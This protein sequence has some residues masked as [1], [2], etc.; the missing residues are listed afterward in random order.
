MEVASKMTAL[1]VRH[2]DLRIL[3]DSDMNGYI[4]TKLQL[5]EANARIAE[6]EAELDGSA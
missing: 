2:A 3:Y 5:T 1:E 4:D 6:L